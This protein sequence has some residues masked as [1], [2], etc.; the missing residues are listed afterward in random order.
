MKKH[1]LGLSVLT[2]TSALALASANASD[3][4]YGGYKDVPG[5]IW[6]GFY[7]GAHVG[8]AWGDLTA[9]D[10]DGYKCCRTARRAIS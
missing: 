1:R 8:G 3:F 4:G 2:L 6:T 9:V 7:L 5:P 10:S